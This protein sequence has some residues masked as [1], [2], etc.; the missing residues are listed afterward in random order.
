MLPVAADENFNGLILRGLQRAVSSHDVVRV[1]DVEVSG[2]SDEKVL[3]W[4]ADRGRVLLT[5]DAATIP[6][7]VRR[8]VEAGLPAPRVLVVSSSLAIGRA[9]GEI[10]LVLE[11]STDE[12]WAPIVLRVPL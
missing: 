6:A 2:A 10:L 9:I 7:L 5:H 4:C 8:R 11:C 12:D 3:E 1:Q